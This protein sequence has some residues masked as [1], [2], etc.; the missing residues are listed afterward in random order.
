M[1]FSTLHDRAVIALS[2]KDMVSFLQ[3]LITQD[4]T[5]L[6]AGEMLYALLLS[7]QGKFLHD[8]FLIPQEERILLDVNKEHV[9]DLVARLNIYKLRSKVNIEQTNI[10]VMACWG[11]GS[12]ILQA[13]YRDLRHPELG[14]RMYGAVK[15]ANGEEGDYEAHRITLGIPDGAKDLHIDKSLPLE[16]GLDKLNAI[17]FSKGCYVGQEV[18]ARSKFRGQVRKA[19][20]RVLSKQPLPPLG[21]AITLNGEMIGELRSTHGTV[22]LALLRIE[23]LANLITPLMAGDVAL[24]LINA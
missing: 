17:S 18:T 1:F 9:T 21:T 4:A 13:A 24:T 6:S 20:Y 10:E 14:V 8:F 2:G 11:E 22:G 23:S 15:I 7:P 19:L 5:Q 3:G 12:D 16:F